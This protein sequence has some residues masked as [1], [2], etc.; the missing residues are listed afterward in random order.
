M[1]ES[2]KSINQEGLEEEISKKYANDTTTMRTR[3]QYAEL[4]RHFAQWGA[5]HLADVRK[6]STNDLEEAAI[7]HSN[8]WYC[9]ALKE[10]NETGT[11]CDGVAAAFIAGAKWQKEQM[12]KDAVDADV[13]LTLHDKTGDISLHTGYLPKE[14]GIKCDDKVRMIIV[15]ED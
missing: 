2:E 13:M 10:L 5:E 3:E 7:Y 9:S 14:L 8:S 1:I 11:G 15:K 6:T 4:A 12:M